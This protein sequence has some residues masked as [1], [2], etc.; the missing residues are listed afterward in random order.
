MKV[1][2]LIGSPTAPLIYFTNAIHRHHKVELVIVE[3]VNES[4]L[5]LINT[6]KK[7]ILESHVPLLVAFIDKVFKYVLFKI[8]IYKKTRMKK[9]EELKYAEACQKWFKD[10]YKS[11]DLT[12]PFLEVEDIN[13]SIVQ[14]ALMK[15]NPDL[16]LDHG[17]SLVKPAVLKLAKQAL[18][19]HWG[20]SPYYRGS[21][22]T[23]QALMNWDIY[24]IGVTIHKLAVQIDGGDI[25][26]QS[27]ATISSDDT[28]RTIPLQLTY[29]G[30]EIVKS[31]IDKLKRKENI[32]FIKQNFNDGFLVREMYW[33]ENTSLFI[34][35][36]NKEKMELML[37]KPSRQAAPIVQID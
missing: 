2:I 34:D 31:T 20:L 33:D 15:I 18:N 7:Q 13:S 14:E 6:K 1:V 12:I 19:L 17:T 3:K 9:E 16:L 21:N 4:K 37:K 32:Q 30:T 10:S 22:C 24:N 36:L 27:R 29:L 23:V 5:K 35:N 11:I 26:A 28:L 25:L 8:N